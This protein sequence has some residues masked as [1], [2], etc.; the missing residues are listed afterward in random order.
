LGSM[1]SLLR[2]WSGT[3]FESVGE[4][5]SDA[6]EVRAV[7]PDAAEKIEPEELDDDVELVRVRK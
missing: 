3:Y 1:V 2:R 6:G 5:H 4:P 7:E